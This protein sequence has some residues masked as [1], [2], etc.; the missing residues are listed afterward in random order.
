MNSRYLFF[1]IALLVGILMVWIT[2][3]SFTQPGIKDL[4]MNYTET[5][6]YRNEN[7]TG[8]VIRIYAVVASDTLWNDMQAYG[9]FMPHTKYGNTKV[10]FFSNKS[11]APLVLDVKNPYFDPVLNTSCIA[12]YEKSAMGEVV[13]TRF[14]FQN[15]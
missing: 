1:V 9:N 4:K 11:Q 7:N 12:M 3:D 5:A 6:F 8:P 15:E 2:V 10:F 13:F 14:P